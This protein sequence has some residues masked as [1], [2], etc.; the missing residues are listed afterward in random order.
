MD[1][2][3]VMHVLQPLHHASYHELRF[4]LSECFALAQM[5]A[6]IP[7]VQQIS[8][9]IQVVSILER[10]RHIHNKG[11]LQLLEQLFLAHD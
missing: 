11:V 9:Q 1:H 5:E 8:H 6:Q 4:C 2:T 7:T 3:L 10:I